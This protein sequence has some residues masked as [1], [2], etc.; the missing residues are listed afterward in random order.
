MKQ[1]LVSLQKFF[2]ITDL[3][4]TCLLSSK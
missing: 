2:W 4:L 3:L 1:S